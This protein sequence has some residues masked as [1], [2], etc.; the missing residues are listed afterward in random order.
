MTKKHFKAIA[1]VMEELGN[2][3][4]PLKL[5]LLHKKIVEIMADKLEKYN[6]L[7]DYQRFIFASGVDTLCE[8]CE[9]VMQYKNGYGLYCRECWGS[10]EPV[11]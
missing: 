6:P 11:K 5:T 3:L 10:N 1:E 2:M 8:D 4:I 7:F 9:A